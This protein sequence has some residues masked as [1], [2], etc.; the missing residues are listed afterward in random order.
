MTSPN[1]TDPRLLDP[2][3]IVIYLYKPKPGQEGVYSF[4]RPVTVRELKEQL[5]RYVSQISIPGMEGNAFEHAESF[6]D[7]FGLRG[8]A[9]VGS[10]VQDSQ[11]YLDGSAGRIF[12]LPSPGHCEGTLIRIVYL[13]SDDTYCELFHFKYL[14][15][16]HVVWSIAKQISEAL[17]KGRY[18]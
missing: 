6:F 15:N 11:T 1:S 12:A 9:A 17:E 5:I 3:R 10:P 2:T 4:D 7:H 16:E 18:I 14:I 13:K 8:A